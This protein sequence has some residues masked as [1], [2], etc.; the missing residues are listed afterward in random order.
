MGTLELFDHTADVGMRVGADSLADLFATAAT[1]LYAYIVANPES[2]VGREHQELALSADHPA[3]LLV[4]WLNELIFRFETKHW[5]GHRFEVEL[6]PD[7]RS[8]TARLH[9]EPLDRERHELDHEVKAA[10]LHAAALTETGRRWHAEVI[11]DI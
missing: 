6:S 5:L 7:G 11:L 2:I 8:L 1:G 3:G 4:A 10:T 9:G